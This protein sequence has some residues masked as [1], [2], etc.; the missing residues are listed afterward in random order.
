MT[1]IKDCALECIKVLTAEK[2]ISPRNPIINKT[3][4]SFVERVASCHVAND[5]HCD[6]SAYKFLP[7]LRGHLARAECEMEKYFAEYFVQKERLNIE[8]VKNDFLYWDNYAT[9]CAKEIEMIDRSGV[10]DQMTQKDRVSFIGS[11]PLPLSAVQIV[12]QKNIAVD[13]IDNDIHA[14]NLSSDLID[15]LGLSEKIKIHHC[16]GAKFNYA[17]NAIVFVASLIQKKS[18]VI[19]AVHNTRIKEPSYLAVRSAEDMNTFLY[20]PFCE[21][22]FDNVKYLHAGKTQYCAK[23]INTT[24]GYFLKRA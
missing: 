5:T 14:C 19:K 18:P 7:Q 3:L 12:L 2:D 21:H 17:D 22:D 1:S 4:G 16:D 23:T 8:D 6:H 24:L 9:L 15:K 13:C 20:E 10:F 11:G